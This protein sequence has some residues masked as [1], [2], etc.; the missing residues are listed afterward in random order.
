MTYIYDILVNFLEQPY[1]FYAWKT[2]DSIDHIKKI[3]IFKVSKEQFSILKNYTIKLE[4]SFFETL[5]NKTEVFDKFTS[6]TIYASLFTNE[7]E[8]LALQFDPSGKQKAISTLL[9]DEQDEIIDIAHALKETTLPIEHKER[10]ERKPFLTRNQEEILT[11]LKKEL[12][13]TYLHQQEKLHYLY[14]ECFNQKCSS[15]EKAYQKLSNLLKEEFQEKHQTL[16]DLLKMSTSK[17]QL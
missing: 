9:L 15:N 7:Q 5:K 16:Y 4:S 17:K 12:D 10:R 8:V 1:E 3:P 14:Y 11:Y 6:H 2:T 13:H